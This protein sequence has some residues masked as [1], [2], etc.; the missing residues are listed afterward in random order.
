MCEERLNTSNQTVSHIDCL[1]GGVV[2]TV[3]RIHHRE[4][5]SNL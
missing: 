5:V 2:Q 4:N 1:E 3:D